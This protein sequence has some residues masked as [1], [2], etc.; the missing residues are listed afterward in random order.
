[1]I[2]RLILLIGLFSFC[3]IKVEAQ[4]TSSTLKSLYKQQK[5]YIS[6]NAKH[7]HFTRQKLNE[8]DSLSFINQ[9]MD[10]VYMLDMYDMGSSIS[11]GCVWNKSKT[12]SYTYGYTVEFK[13]LGTLFTQHLRK[14]VS[15]WDID[16]IKRDVQEG[17]IPVSPCRICANRF[18]Y[19]F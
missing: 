15:S 14:L 13:D 3:G 6:G 5:K 17:S 16:G 9:K 10:T 12:I 19:F 11:Y 1:M 2:Y 18:D 8:M 7:F 4:L